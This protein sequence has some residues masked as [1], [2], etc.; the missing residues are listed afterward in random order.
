MEGMSAETEEGCCWIESPESRI[1]PTWLSS[2][3]SL[4]PGPLHPTYHAS[5]SSP[6]S[7]T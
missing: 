5:P 4:S 1:D 7:T 6:V 3:A 2:S